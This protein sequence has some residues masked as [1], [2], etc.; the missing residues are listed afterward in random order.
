LEQRLSKSAGSILG[1]DLLQ[2]IECFDPLLGAPGVALEFDPQLVNVEVG[3][4]QELH[5]GL[6]DED[7]IQRRPL[8]V[9]VGVEPPL[10][11][12]AASARDGVDPAPPP[13]RSPPLAARHEALGLELGKQRIE[14]PVVDQ[15]IPRNA[16]GQAPLERVGMVRLVSDQAEQYVSKSYTYILGMDMNETVDRTTRAHVERRGPVAL[17]RMDHADNRLHPQLL[18]ALDAV[19]DD[20]EAGDGAAAL[21]VTGAGKFFS[22]GLDLEYMSSHPDDAERTLARVHCLFAR[23][24]VLE[25]PTV[26]AINGHAFAAGA[27]LALTFDQAVM[28]EDRG[29]VCLPEADLGLPFTPGMNALIT[30]RLGAPVAHEAM[31]TARRYGGPDAL[32]ARIVSELAPEAEVVERA[33]RRAETLAGKPRDAIAA[34]KRGLCGEAIERLMPSRSTIDAGA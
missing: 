31:V 29:Y 33:V 5:E 13:G 16:R 3:C 2:R 19:L 24:L 34:I 27:M 4:E 22:N 6:C 14:D 28:R 25:V 21:V 32:A 20:I 26:A 11:L 30:A 8:L 15:S 17:V 10:E 12:R 1:R 9:V 18:D 7:L 23:L